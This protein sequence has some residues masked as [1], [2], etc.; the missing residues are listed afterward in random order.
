MVFQH[1]TNKKIRHYLRHSILLKGKRTVLPRVISG[2]FRTLLLKQDVL[3]TVEF[4][5]TADCNVNCEMCYASRIKKKNRQYLTPKDYQSIWRQA[6]NLGAFSAII[7][8]GEPVIRKELFEIIKS[9]D[10]ENTIIAIV[11]NSILIDKNLLFKLKEAGVNVIHFSLNSIDAEENDKMRD[12]QGHFNHV[13]DLCAVAKSLGIEVCL[14]TIVSHNEI[15]RVKKVAEYAQQHDIGVVF[16]LACPSGNWAGAR[17]HLLT[18][19]EWKIVDQFMK[20]NP[21]IRSDWTINFSLKNECP[22]GREKICISPYGDVMGCGMNFISFGNVLEESLEKIWKRM[23]GWEQFKKRSALCLTALDPEYLE[24]Y[25]LPVVGNSE[26]PV[27][28][29]QHPVHPMCIKK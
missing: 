9:L 16:S 23:C 11:T 4:T 26:L 20:E 21:F 10:P 13:S 24:E 29:D 17:E 3:R 1:I 8:G 25:L 27:P 19:D 2:Y 14:S 22:G 12:F 6:K 15:E 18:I 7:S 28:I 5:I